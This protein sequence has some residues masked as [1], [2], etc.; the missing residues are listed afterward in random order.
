MP[1]ESVGTTDLDEASSEAAEVSDFEGQA[2]PSMPCPPKKR[3]RRPKRNPVKPEN[4][5]HPS[6]KAVPAFNCI[7]PATSPLHPEPSPGLIKK[8]T[9]NNRKRRAARKKSQARRRSLQ[10]SLL[11]KALKYSTSL[12]LRALPHATSSYIGTSTKTPN[13]RSARRPP[14]GT[15]HASHQP[16][17]RLQDLLDKGYRVLDSQSA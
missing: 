16:H 1:I 8:S 12:D 2:C 9:L 10:R 3:R 14:T 4:N 6:G 15:D 17:P 11:E 13:F 5:R 7:F